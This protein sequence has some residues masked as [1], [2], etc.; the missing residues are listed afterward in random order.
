MGIGHQGKTLS[1]MLAEKDRLFRETGHI[2]GLTRLPLHE[3]DPVKITRFNTRLTDLCIAARNKAKLVAASP[4]LRTFG[5]CLWMLQGPEGD[6]VTASHG[7]VG[8]TGTSAVQVRKIIGIDFEDNPGIR[9]G[10]IISNNDPVYGAAHAA[11]NHTFVP[12]FYGDELI[13]WACGMNHI[14]EVGG[15][16]SPGS[17]PTLAPTS[18]TDGW[19][20]PPMKIGENDRIHKWSDLLWE[21]RTRM[22]GFNIMDERA[23][24]VG[25]LM[26][27]DQIL[28]VVEEYGVDYFRQALKEILERERR[29]V[30]RF[31]RNRMVPGLYE[32]TLFGWHKQRG[33]IGPVMPEADR[34]WVVHFP[35]QLTIEPD[36]RFIVDV[37]GTTSQDYFNWNANEGAQRLAFSWWW[38]PQ[39]VYTISVNTAMDYQIEMKAAEGSIFKPTNPYLGTSIGLGA[40]GLGLVASLVNACSQSFFAR[41]IVEEVYTQAMG[42]ILVGQGGVFDNGLPWAF[43]D[44]A[45]TGGFATGAR[46]YRDG[47]FNCGCMVNPESDIGEVEEWEH[48]EPPLLTLGRKIVPNMCG[49]G[50]YRGGPGY[51]TIWLALKPGKRCVLNSSLGLGAAGHTG[52]GL[53]GG[54]PAIGQWCFVWHDTNINDLIENGEGYPASSREIFQWIKDGKLRVGQTE[55][56]AWQS[57]N[58]EMRDGDI[59]VHGSHG[60]PGFGDCIERE[61]AL[62][63]KDLNEGLITPDCAESVYGVIAQLANGG[64][65]VNVKASQRARARIRAKRRQAMPARDWWHAEREKILAKDFAANQDLLSMWRDSLGNP[66]FK[67]RF[68]GF[69]QLPDD[70][71]L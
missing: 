19:V 32:R 41:G 44:F 33:V 64:W 38:L 43:T 25:A 42:Y 55:F 53:S 31:V 45:M 23:R 56:Y 50:R 49:H 9:H 20:Y 13:A 2:Y 29:R 69:W 27:R 46:P 62:V 4:V 10:D 68:A 30:V 34:D 3:E 71:T 48:Y 11:D 60:N 61:P 18:F 6:V 47:D 17:M 14:S 59:Y 1:E 67:A 15:A 40:G 5:E 37:H 22:G 16:F 52:D 57:P 36:G 35:L 51:E 70:Y 12:I 63:E 65:H 26:V 8:H 28:E 66:K 7:L 24:T 21:R 54:Y 39:I 58:L